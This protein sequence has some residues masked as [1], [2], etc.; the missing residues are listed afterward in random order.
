M[1][2]DGVTFRELKGIKSLHSSWD[3]ILIFDIVIVS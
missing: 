3:I 1:L 2:R